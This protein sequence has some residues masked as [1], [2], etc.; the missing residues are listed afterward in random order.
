MDSA[1][2]YKPSG[3]SG[4]AVVLVPLFAIPLSLVMGIVYAYISVYN[5]LIGVISFLLPLGFGALFGWGMTKAVSLAKCRNPQVVLLTCSLATVFV[6]YCVWAFFIYVFLDHIGS[7]VPLTTVFPDAVGIFN[8]MS[9]IAVNGWYTV[10]GTTPSG[11]VLWLFWVCEAGMIAYLA[12]SLPFN[13]VKETLFCEDC[14]VWCAAKKD[15]ARYVPTSEKAKTERIKS[16]DLT[17]L[18]DLKPATVTA[19]I[20]MRLDS[21]RCGKCSRTS[22][23]QLSQ[24]TITTDKHGKPQEKAKKLTELVILTPESLAKLQEAMV[25][26]ASVPPPAQPAPPVPLTSPESTLPATESSSS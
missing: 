22:T 25:K 23:F 7:P 2:V 14:N 19:P 16:G 4:N 12:V 24:I 5:P 15:L 8:T 6:L 21:Q 20:Y 18:A 10:K 26:Q 13:H 3:E 17:V 1:S 9:Q 11:I